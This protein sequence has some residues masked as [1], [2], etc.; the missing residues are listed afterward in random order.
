MS[1]EII[2]Y[3]Y[4]GDKVTRASLSQTEGF[5]KLTRKQQSFIYE[6]LTNGF[7]ASQAAIDAGYSKKTARS[8]GW[9][10]LKNHAVSKVVE[11]FKMEIAAIYD[12]TAPQLLDMVQELIDSCLDENGKI[13]DKKMYAEG[14]KLMAK[15]SGNDVPSS[16]INIQQN[17]GELKIIMVP[18]EKE[19]E[20]EKDKLT[21]W[22]GDGTS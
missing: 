5:D 7:I 18:K 3:N 17:D 19:K 6:Y 12:I 14:I 20:K 16:Q 22:D 21:K 11:L 2:K 8:E 4:K 13:K 9:K 15:L 1:E 10:I